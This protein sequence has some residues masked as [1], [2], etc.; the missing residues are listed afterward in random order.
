MIRQLKVYHGYLYAIVRNDHL[1]A[2]NWWVQVWRS[3]DGSNWTQV[4]ENGLGDTYNNNDG[5]GIEVYY[6]CLYIGTGETVLV[7][8]NARIYRTCDGINFVEF[9]NNQLG[10]V[11]NNGAIALKSYGGYLYVATYRYYGGIGGTEVW[12][13]QEIDS[14]GDGVANEQDNCPNKCNPQQ[15]DADGDGL[16]DVCDP[17]PG[18]G[19][20]AQPQCELECFPTTTTVIVT[21]STSSTLP[22]NTTSINTTTTTSVN[23]T[24]SV[25]TNSSTTSTVLSVPNAPTNLTATAISATQINLSWRD[26]SESED[27]FKIERADSSLGPFSEIATVYTNVSAYSSTGL[28]RNTRYFY[29]VRAYNAAGNSGY[30]NTASATTL[31]K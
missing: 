9:S 16:G 14:D 30:S 3:P 2:G 24:T 21:T 28:K 19:G 1:G 6:D 4:G 20:C 12:R 23:T 8:K 15:L 17:D 13:Y 25:A 26:N 27:G 29:R 5:R 31:K 11:Y 22:T 18:C 7:S 10:D